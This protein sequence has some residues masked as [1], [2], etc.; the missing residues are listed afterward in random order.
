MSRVQTLTDEEYRILLAVREATA[1]KPKTAS[2]D[3][4]RE[5]DTINYELEAIS[6]STWEETVAS[7]QR[8]IM[9]MLY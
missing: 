2:P 6:G 1:I 8:R 9:G 7:V 5:L 4:Q 3:V